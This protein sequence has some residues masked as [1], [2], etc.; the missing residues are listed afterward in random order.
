MSK[1]EI[2]KTTTINGTSSISNET[3]LDKVELL[4][5]NSNYKLNIPEILIEGE[6]QMMVNNNTNSS[7]L[8]YSPYWKLFKYF[9]S[10]KSSSS[11]SNL[12]QQH[13][14]LNQTI[15]LGEPISARSENVITNKTSFELS[16][17][18][19]LSTNITSNITSTD[20]ASSINSSITEIE[21]SSIS[22]SAAPTNL[23]TP[24]STKENNG[25]LAIKTNRCTHPE[26]NS[27]N[28][29]EFSID[30]MLA[31]RLCC[32]NN[33]S[34]LSKGSSFTCKRIDKS[35][36]DRALP[37]IKCCLR[38]LSEILDDYFKSGNKNESS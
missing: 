13:Q 23:N 31:V 19:A 32:L 18:N 3:Y 28:C 12:T 7:F 16:S 8:F 21:T 37:I 33:N 27:I 34:I 22:Q 10:K 9:I 14:Q 30:K 35:E 11:S 4:K 24:E 1:N 5:V 17:S 20:N 15:Q 6:H 29:S 38:D 26:L 2:N 25:E 36:C